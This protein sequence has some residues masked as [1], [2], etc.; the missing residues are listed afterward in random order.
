MMKK[1]D[2]VIDY[3]QLNEVVLLAQALFYS[4]CAFKSY[5]MAKLTF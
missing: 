2:R 4:H 3:E 1:Y 5:I